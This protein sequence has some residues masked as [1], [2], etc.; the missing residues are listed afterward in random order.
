MQ[1]TVGASFDQAILNCLFA[2]VAAGI[3]FQGTTT[4]IV[5]DSQGTQQTVRFT[6]P[7]NILIWDDITVLYDPLVYVPATGDVAVAAA[8]AAYGGAQATAKDVVASSLAAAVLPTYVNGVLV[9][10]DPGVLDVPQVLTNI[11]AISQTPS[12]W[13]PSTSYA[14]GA[15]FV[16]N[17][18][19]TYVCT[20]AGISAAVGGGPSTN[21]A[22]I[23]DGAA[24]WR[25]LGSTIS[26]TTRQ[27][28]V[29]DTSRVTVHSRPITP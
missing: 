24:V 28:A 26:I 18:G 9:A 22:A 7:A 14:Q 15:S 21:G 10:G 17:D 13:Q 16:T 11:A 20:T 5:I 3:A 1:A 19:R 29:H 4:G 23:L 25:S 2:S 12:A 27:L 8:I 6:R